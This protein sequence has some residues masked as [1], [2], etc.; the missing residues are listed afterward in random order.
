MICQTLLRFLRQVGIT[1]LFLVHCDAQQNK[2]APA[3]PSTKVQVS[4]SHG[5]GACEGFLY[6][7]DKG[8]RYADTI[9]PG[10]GMTGTHAFAC[11]RK[12][13][14]T[15][16]FV[17]NSDHHTTSSPVLWLTITCESFANPNKQASFVFEPSMRCPWPIQPGCQE[18]PTEEARK[19]YERAKEVFASWGNNK[20][21]SPAP[22][23]KR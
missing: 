9:R 17:D 6:I 12:A 19:G 2:N 3:V 23:P 22:Q 18:G 8:V 14:T 1:V 21:A 5:F 4:H 20:N 16:E 11:T 13:I 7:D 15:Y 10:T